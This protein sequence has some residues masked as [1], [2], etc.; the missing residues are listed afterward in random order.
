MKK[1]RCRTGLHGSFFFV[2]L[3]V[4]YRQQ[5]QAVNDGKS[6]TIKIAVVS[7]DPLF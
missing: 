5:H 6:Y 7:S 1:P 4:F 3:P 2:I